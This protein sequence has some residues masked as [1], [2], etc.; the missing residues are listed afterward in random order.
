MRGLLVG[1]FQP[2]HRGHLA[3][4]RSLRA[5]P[6]AEPLLLV[7]GS[8]EQS[9]TWTNPFTGG[10]RFEMIERAL[11]EARVTG[12]TLVPVADIGRHAL[13]VRYLEGLLPAFDRVYSRNP[14]TLMLF[15]R[16]GYSTV[17]PP[18]VQRARFEGA[19]IRARLARGEPVGAFVPPAVAR[20]LT[21]L[22]AAERLAA[23]R[24]ARDR[25]APPARSDR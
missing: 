3:L 4:V 2:F 12:V 23:L 10:E 15:E 1:R 24:P 14:L 25:R 8:A 9:Y 18:L 7:I 20:Y 17:R 6:D 21:Q 11:A 13:W 5:G 22:N 16:A 19:R